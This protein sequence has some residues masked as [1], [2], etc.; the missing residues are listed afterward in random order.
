MLT[1]GPSELV[2]GDR[3]L[4]QSVLQSNDWWSDKNSSNKMK[5]DF[6]FRNSL[7]SVGLM[8]MILTA[9]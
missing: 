9:F 5:N 7:Q 1:K 8:M 6:A 2:T 3:N 4:D